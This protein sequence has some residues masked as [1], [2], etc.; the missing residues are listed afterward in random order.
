[1]SDWSVGPVE[2]PAPLFVSLATIERAIT[3]VDDYLSPMA[4]R[5]FGDAAL[6]DDERG[7]ANIAKLIVARRLGD[8]DGNGRVLINSREV[9]RLKLPKLRNADAVKAAFSVL[10]E[11]GWIRSAP[12]R[13]GKGAGRR[14]DDHEINPYVFKGNCQ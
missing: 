5:V 2:K 8:P 11:N 10:T 12:S 14:R 7:A 4:E 13:E 1:L 9:Q 6:P 3:F